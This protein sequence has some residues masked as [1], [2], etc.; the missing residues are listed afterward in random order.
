MDTLENQKAKNPS[1]TIIRK[2][3]LI[4]VLKYLELFPTPVNFNVLFGSHL[5][6]DT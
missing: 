4:C 2:R 5:F 6:M 1:G 3:Y